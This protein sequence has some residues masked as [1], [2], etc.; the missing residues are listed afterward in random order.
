MVV[1]IDCIFSG[2]LASGFGMTIDLE[3]PDLSFFGVH[4]CSFVSVSSLNF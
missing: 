4:V 3:F 2:L 1:V